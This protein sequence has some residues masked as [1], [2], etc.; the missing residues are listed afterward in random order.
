MKGFCGFI[1]VGYYIILWFQ[2]M[3]TTEN[4]SK[5]TKEWKKSKIQELRDELSKRDSNP[6][7]PGP[8]PTECLR[9]SSDLPENAVGEGPELDVKQAVPPSEDAP[10]KSEAVNVEPPSGDETSQLKT[11]TKK[12]EDSIMAESVDP[13]AAVTPAVASVEKPSN[14]GADNGVAGV[15]GPLQLSDL[16]KKHRRAER[17]GL[18][19]Q[20][21]EEEKRNSRAARFGESTNGTPKPTSPGLGEAK[22]S[23]EEKRKARAERFGLALRSSADDEAKKK[24]RLARFGVD[25]KS[26]SLED[27]KKKA[28]AARFAPALDGS[29]SEVNKKLKPDLAGT[30]AST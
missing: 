25:V 18:A 16:E 21:S 23:E 15:A 8:S 11:V 28:R 20:L 19:L 1:S 24:A 13:V 30:V 4:S 5:V 6:G 14:E 27:D 29:T 17:F 22:I 26:A 3:A 12:C 10:E 7:A 2:V 9:I